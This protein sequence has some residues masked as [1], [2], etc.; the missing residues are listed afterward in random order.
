MPA[1]SN[2]MAAPGNAIEGFCFIPTSFKEAKNIIGGRAAES[3]S[4]SCFVH[5]RHS[6]FIT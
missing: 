5:R 2:K 3:E 1:A 6:A 4:A